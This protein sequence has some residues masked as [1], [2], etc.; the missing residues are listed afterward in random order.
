MEH[1]F[2]YVTCCLLP[3]VQKK[4]CNGTSFIISH[5]QVLK[6]IVMKIFKLLIKIFDKKLLPYTYLQRKN[7]K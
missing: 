1:W 5:T 3:S 4:E 6:Y 2:Q 7:Q